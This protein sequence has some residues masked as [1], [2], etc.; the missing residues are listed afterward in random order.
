MHFISQLRHSKLSERCCPVSLKLDMR[1]SLNMRNKD[2]TIAIQEANT[3][4]RMRELDLSQ[5]SFVQIPYSH[6]AA[7]IRRHKQV[8]EFIGVTSSYCGVVLF[9]FLVLK[10]VEF[11]IFS[12]VLKHL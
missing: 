7:G 10:M 2:V 11:F 1:D 3:V 5:E 8:D 12:V 4:Y 6:H 9:L